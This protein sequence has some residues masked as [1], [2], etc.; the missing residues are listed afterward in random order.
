MQYIMCRLNGGDMQE[1]QCSKSLYKCVVSGFAYG[2][3][4][5]GA[6]S[7]FFLL[8]VTTLKSNLISGIITNGN[9]RGQLTHQDTETLKRLIDKGVLLC[10]EHVLGDTMSYYGSIIT[11]LVCIIGVMGVFAFVYVRNLSLDH[12]EE[13]VKQFANEHAKHFFDSSAF[14]KDLE[15]RTDT[16]ARKYLEDQFGSILEDLE[17]IQPISEKMGELDERIEA[18]ESAINMQ[19]E[20]QPPQ[21]QG[22]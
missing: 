11:V 18:M 10:P 13:K 1:T 15:K 3:G 5:A 19:D 17:N 20:L 22:A 16:I 9:E 4:V 6:V 14:D 2:L 7:F 8:W 21:N 12:A